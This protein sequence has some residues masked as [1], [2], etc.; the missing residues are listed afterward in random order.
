MALPSQLINRFTC[1]RDGASHFQTE[2]HSASPYIRLASWKP[3]HK[4]AWTGR[5]EAPGGIG[6]ILGNGTRCPGAV[7]SQIPSRSGRVTS[8]NVARFLFVFL[9]QA[10]RAA[11]SG[12]RPVSTYRHKAIAS[13]RARATMAIRFTRPCIAPTRSRN[14]LERALFG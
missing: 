14:H 13:L 6:P 2:S 7:R 4:P 8:G 5:S 3:D 11:P 9:H 1:C 12:T 10:F